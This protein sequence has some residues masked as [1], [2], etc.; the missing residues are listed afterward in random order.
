MKTDEIVF[1]KKIENNSKKYDIETSFHNYFANGIL[2]HNCSATY[3]YKKGI[4]RDFFGIYSRELK[5]KEDDNSNWSK[6]AIK[7]NLKKQLKSYGETLWIQGEIAGPGIQKNRCKLKELELFVFNVY[8]VKQH[9]YLDPVEMGLVC[10]FLGLKTVPV[11]NHVISL[12]DTTIDKLV[13][14]SKGS[15]ESGPDDLREGIVIRE[16][17][18][19]SL[20][21]ISFKVISPDYLLKYNI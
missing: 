18:D 14:M 2:V 1:I 12:K 3:Y 19:F 11:V 6:I 10:T 4:F 7:Y 21:R 15:Y 5:K 17:N 16:L 20:N 9:R 8:N 13:E